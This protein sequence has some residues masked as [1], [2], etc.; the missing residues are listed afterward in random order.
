M[1]LAGQRRDLP[2]R[3]R[4]V[5]PVSDPQTPTLVIESAGD[6]Y[7]WALL[8]ALAEPLLSLLGRTGLTA[9]LTLALLRL[10]TSG[11]AVADELG[12]DDLAD[13]CQVS[14]SEVEQTASRLAT[15]LTPLLERLQPVVAHLTDHATA[16][17]FDPDGSEFGS[18]EEILTALRSLPEIGEGAAALVTRVR[19]A[20][21]L[22]ELRKA[23]GLD[24]AAFNQTLSELGGRYQPLDYTA[25]HE[26]EFGLY[27]REHWAEISLRLRWGRLPLH[28][29]YE[30]QLDW[31][32]L[33]RP[34]AL[35]AD[36]AW[37]ATHDHLEPGLLQARWRSWHDSS[38]PTY[39]PTGRH[40]NRSTRSEPA[41]PTWSALRRRTWENY[42]PR[43]DR[44]HWRPGPR[45]LRLRRSRRGSAKPARLSRS[46]RLHATDRRA[47]HLAAAAGRLAQRHAHHHR[48]G[49]AAAHCNR[50]RRT[51]ERGGTRTSR[52]R[53]CPAQ[54]G[55]RRAPSRRRRRPRR[56]ATRP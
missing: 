8:E 51:A 30:P 40:S 56:A 27:A 36:P 33:H 44:P 12:Y 50:P 31:S 48:P 7:D 34:A 15:A 26:E 45:R 52:A 13:A 38:A 42:R 6:S 49:H 28:Q 21:T 35:T 47:D 24:L 55:A 54:P 11:A 46:S 32:H 3:M 2:S 18:E 39:P 20:A 19:N 41:T 43:L 16:R 37:A 53:T 22:D 14:R 29:R 17:P 25:A 4:S 23:L 9:E 5:L 10:K 1:R